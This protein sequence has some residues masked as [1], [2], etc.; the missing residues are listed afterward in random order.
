[1][2]KL[3]EGNSPVPATVYK[4]VNLTTAK[5]ILT[6]GSLQ[7]S[8]PFVFNDP[9]DM[10]WNPG[11]QMRTSEA[12]AA[13]K[14]LG[15]RIFEE[16]EKYP[17]VNPVLEPG[18]AKMAELFKDNRPEFDFQ[19]QKVVNVIASGRM[20]VEGYEKEIKPSLQQ[21]RVLCLSEAPNSILMW[22][23][24]SKDHKGAVLEFDGK[25]LAE[26][27]SCR[28]FK[29]DYQKQFPIVIDV[30][31]W[32]KSLL[33]GGTPRFSDDYLSLILS[34][35]WKEWDYEREIRFLTNYPENPKESKSFY[36][37]GA[38]ALRGV[39][40]GCNSSAKDEKIIRAKLR[41]HYAGAYLRKCRL[42]PTGFS[43]EAVDEAP[44][45]A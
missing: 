25:K 40:L 19:I 2:P 8:S 35:K 26:C 29:V 44:G 5:A 18:R 1:M 23:H 4:Y 41:S 31:V 9:F 12:A 36:R 7:W 38:E 10:Q 43:V 11:W 33:L 45:E 32:A 39:S 30:E 22:S 34:T 21:L 24:Y 14:A 17:T 15:Y 27:I 28:C 6:N 42:C 3:V 16:P 13:I 20:F 37:F